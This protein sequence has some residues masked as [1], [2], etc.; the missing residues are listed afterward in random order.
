MS[1]KKRKQANAANDAEAPSKKSKQ[2]DKPNREKRVKKYKKANT[3]FHV[4]KASLVISIPPIFA[5]NPRAG[6]E[7]ML[8]SMVMRSAIYLLLFCASLKVLHHARYIPAFQG[9]VLSHSNLGF[10]TKEATIQADCPS[11]ICAVGF[12]AT[13]WSPR[14]GMKLGRS[15]FVQ[16]DFNL[17]KFTG[18]QWGKLTFVLPITYPFCY[19]ALSM[20]QYHGITFQLTSGNSNTV[21]QRMIPNLDQVP[22][23]ML[24]TIEATEHQRMGKRM[25]VVNGCI[26]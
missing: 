6:V 18:T 4:V 11:L 15:P 2:E 14:I 8:D 26:A 13:I 16:H 24:L 23:A 5:S 25:A 10:L 1:T 7:E 22:K 9:V 21:L 19:I 3:E 17:I 20:F 12:D